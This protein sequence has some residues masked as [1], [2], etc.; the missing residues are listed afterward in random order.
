[1]GIFF[2]KKGQGSDDRGGRRR[3]EQPVRQP[4]L[5]EGQDSY[6]FRRSRTLTGSLASDVPVSKSHKPDLKSERLKLHELHKH[7][8][9]L[10]SSLVCL[11]VLSLFL[12]CMIANSVLLAEKRF[13]AIAI[14][15]RDA[16]A[17]EQSVTD[18]INNHPSE[19]FLLTLS[20][21][22]LNQYLQKDHP[23]VA[24]VAVDTSWTGVGGSITM[25][26]R[27]P[28]VAW[29]I[30]D[31]RFYV[32]EDGVAFNKSYGQ[33]PTLHV[34]DASGFTPDAVDEASVASRRFISYLGQLLGALRSQEVGAVER[35][36]IPASIRQLDIYLQGRGYPIKTHVDR[37]PYAQAQDLKHAL[38]FFDQRQVVPQYVDVRVEGKAFYR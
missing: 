23:E 35:V 27:K 30:A 18:Y 14:P 24:A 26:F 6:M 7:R 22:R 38:T 1:M 29:K 5:M 25:Q 2:G 21:Q 15:A 32:D 11:G 31:S 10:R 33:E 12:V 16:A 3:D 13:V 34:E 9:I 36:V 19:A 20:E 8:R 28:I 37:D 17:L 4:R